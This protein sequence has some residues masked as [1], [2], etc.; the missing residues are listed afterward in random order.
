[1]GALHTAVQQGKA[2]YAGISSYSPSRTRRAAAILRDLG[3]PLL[4]HQPSYSMFNRWVED[5]LLEACEDEGV[6]I[7]A[8]A[9]L[10][11]GL[12][13]DRYLDGIPDDSRLRVGEQFTEDM[14]SDENLER[15]RALSA[16]AAERG[17][18][19]AQMAIAWVLRD[20]R[21]TST[22]VGASSLRQLEQNLAAVQQLAFSDD[23]LR[24]IDRYAVEAGINLWEVPSTIP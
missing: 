22:V 8:F 2:L 6:G 24:E 11:H 12:L 7:I 19:L 5:G 9:A 4:I 21:V 10:A 23:E 17:Q 1:M 14:I 16:I 20:A 3:T 13:T 15:V 18:T